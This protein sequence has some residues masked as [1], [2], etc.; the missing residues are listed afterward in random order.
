M[1]YLNDSHESFISGIDLKL[2]ENTIEVGDVLKIEVKTLVP[3]ASIPYNSI[4]D[5]S[6]ANTSLE[7]MQLQGYLVNNSS[8][9]TFPVLG[10]ISTNDLNFIQLE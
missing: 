6:A 1:I 8:M 7:I 3:E 9:I 5:F 4:I 2:L 10:L